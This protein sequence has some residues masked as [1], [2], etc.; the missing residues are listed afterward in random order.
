M[1]ETLPPIWRVHRKDANQQPLSPEDYRVAEEALGS[2][3]LYESIVA[4]EAILHNPC[5]DQLKSKAAGRLEELCRCAV[6]DPKCM[7]LALVL[8]VLNVPHS[9]WESPEIIEEFAVVAATSNDPAFRMNSAPLLERL[10]HYGIETAYHLLQKL[11]DDSDEMVRSNSQS[12][13]KRIGEA[14]GIGNRR[15]ES[16]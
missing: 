10:S 4:C 13:L 3:E 2:N 14:G 7:H 6:T 12:C 9:E 11:A 15:L 5:S 16:D 1:S 8:A